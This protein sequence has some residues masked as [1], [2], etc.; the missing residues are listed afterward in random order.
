MVN[1]SYAVRFNEVIS[2][3]IWL[4]NKYYQLQFMSDCVTGD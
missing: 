2:L 3:N 4:K 1:R